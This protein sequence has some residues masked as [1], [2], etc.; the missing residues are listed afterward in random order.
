M[1]YSDRLHAV[2]SILDALAGLVPGDGPED[3][4]ADAVRAVDLAISEVRCLERAAVADSMATGSTLH[5][6]VSR[7]LP[8]GDR[9][10]V[11]PDDQFVRMD[12]D[13]GGP[14]LPRTIRVACEIE[15]APDSSEYTVRIPGSPNEVVSLD[16]GVVY[17]HKMRAILSSLRPDGLVVWAERLG[18]DGFQ[19]VEDALKV[20][21][22][23]GD[24]VDVENP[25][26][27][28]ADKRSL[29]DLLS[30]VRLM[31]DEHGLDDLC[32][33]L[34]AALDAWRARGRPGPSGGAR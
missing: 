2:A 11:C 17:R 22:P 20:F 1:R 28:A 4:L 14:G 5:G 15:L 9:V 19:S 33:Q 10:H 13:G 27:G 16:D 31:D 7:V 3:E 6:V 24:A 30:V 8:G 32:D 21:E 25:C 29:V 23:E 26:L 34:D 12:G 18:N